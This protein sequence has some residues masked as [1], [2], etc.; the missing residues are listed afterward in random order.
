MCCFRRFRWLSKGALVASA[1]QHLLPYHLLSLDSFTSFFSSP[2]CFLFFPQYIYLFCSICSV[3]HHILHLSVLGMSENF[4]SKGHDAIWRPRHV[5]LRGLTQHN[6]HTH[7][8]KK[9]L[10]IPT[11]CSSI[12][13]KRDPTRCI[14][15]STIATFTFLSFFFFPP[16]TVSIKVHLEDGEKKGNENQL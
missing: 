13:L 12:Q 7:T 6:T 3:T 5:S 1:P 14:Y 4:A 15:V 10:G 9:D 8:H 2:T 11:I 16:P